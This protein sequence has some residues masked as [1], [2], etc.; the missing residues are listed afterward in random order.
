MSIINSQPFKILIDNRVLECLSERSRFL[1]KE[2]A[3]LDLLNRRVAEPTTIT[4]NERTFVLQEGE[5]E[6]SVNVLAEEWKW[7]R[8]KVRKFLADLNDAGCIV[9][10][11]L[12]YASVSTFPCIINSP[13][14][15]A[16]LSPSLNEESSPSDYDSLSP[17]TKEGNTPSETPDLIQSLR[18]DQDPLAL[19]EVTRTRLKSVIDRFRSRLPLLECPDYDQRT[20]KAIYS[21]YILGM[22]GDDELMDRLLSIIA[23]DPLKNGKM[24][25]MTGRK[26]DKESFTSLFSPRWQE[27]LFP[28]TDI[29]EPEPKL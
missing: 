17:S 22:N 18:Y 26:T 11:K 5:A 6:T 16:V 15:N 20:E 13:S 28:R 10:R 21:V 7:D 29:S 27:L 2:Q 24:A 8:K 23:K 19:D 14:Q 25:S 4:K 9:T 3:F 12:P 1:S